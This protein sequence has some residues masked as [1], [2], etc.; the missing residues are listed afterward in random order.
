VNADSDV[1]SLIAFQAL[2]KALDQGQSLREVYDD[3]QDALQDIQL[4]FNQGQIKL[5]DRAKA[6]QFYYQIGSRLLACIDPANPS[7][8]TISGELKETLADKVFC[9]FSLF[10][11][12]PDIW[13]IDQIF[14]IVPLQRLDEEPGR[15]G[16]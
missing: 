14:P 8:Q 15:R 1:D 3:L 16:I 7:L 5:G 10:Q 11:S 4:R 13:A 9:N 2:N 6:E 12:M